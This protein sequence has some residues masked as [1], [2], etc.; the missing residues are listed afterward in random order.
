MANAHE[1]Q[2]PVGARSDPVGGDGAGPVGGPDDG[3]QPGSLGRLSTI[4]AVTVSALG[5]FVDIFDLLLFAMVRKDSLKE[6]L[7][8]RLAGLDA[9]AQDVMLRDWGVWLDNTLQT[10]GLLVGGVLWGVLA[11]RRGRLSVL[12]GSIVLYS[13]ANLLNGCIADVDPQ[14]AL[15]FLHWFGL[16]SAIRQYEVLRVV[17]GIGLAGELG[18]GITLV[19]ELVTPDRRGVATTIVAAVGICGAIGGYFVTQAFSWRASFLI[20]G[21]LGL[22]LLALRFGVVESGMFSAVQRAHRPG[23]GAV[24]RLFWPRERLVRYLSVVLIALPIWFVV[25]V[26]VKYSDLITRSMGV[27]DAERPQPGR[28]IMWCYVGLALGDLASGLASQWWRSRR[29]S[30]AAFLGITAIG[31]VA[32]FTLGRAQPALGTTYAIIA[33]L[34][35]GAGYWAVFVTTAAEHFGTDLRATAATTAPNLVRWSAAGSAA[36]WLAFER[37]IGIDDPAAPW[38]AAAMTGAVVMVLAVLG[39]FGLRETYGTSLDWTED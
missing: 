22:G 5:Y 13:V 36:L 10:S 34:G 32:Y 33:V 14:G 35:F 16:G 20:G 3:A 23:R 8:E 28:A 9:A 29:A 26:C 19:A 25:G 39:W 24:W 31:L 21:G 12:F 6:V 38:Q 1:P 11:D 18:A 15:G 2:P 4:L 27:L 30:I 37:M 7:G 17:A